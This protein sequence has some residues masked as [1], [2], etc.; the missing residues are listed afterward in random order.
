MIDARH[1]RGIECSAA[2]HWLRSRSHCSATNWVRRMLYL[3]LHSAPHVR[4]STCL[5]ARVG[6][7]VRTLSVTVLRSRRAA[8]AA[9]QVPA[10]VV[11]KLYLEL[12]AARR[13]GRSR[14]TDKL[15]LNFFYVVFI[16]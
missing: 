3:D 13:C 9:A 11:G 2:L 6:Q 10:S 8:D 14:S 16:A 1:L 12:A 4:Q 7:G 5:Q 15:P